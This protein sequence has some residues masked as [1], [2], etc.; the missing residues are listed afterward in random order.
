LIIFYPQTH[1]LLFEYQPTN[2]FS[3]LGSVFLH[4]MVISNRSIFQLN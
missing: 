3:C 2:A 1:R 4:G